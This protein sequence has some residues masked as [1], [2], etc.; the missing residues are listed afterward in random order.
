MNWI[1]LFDVRYYETCLLLFLPNEIVNTSAYAVHSFQLSGNDFLTKAYNFYHI[2][3]RIHRYIIN[4]IF[5]IYSSVYSQ[6]RFNVAFYSRVVSSIFLFV[7][8]FISYIIWRF[9]IYCCL[10]NYAGSI[11]ENVSHQIF[12][13]LNI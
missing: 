13:C 7:N 4:S 9:I 10:F 5:M 1:Y 6:V 2:D 11:L 8:K 3:L 12:D